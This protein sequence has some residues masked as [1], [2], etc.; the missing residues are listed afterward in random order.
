LFA[1][2]PIAAFLLEEFGEGLCWS[3]L[4][5]PLMPC[6]D[7]YSNALCGLGACLGAL[8]GVNESLKGLVWREKLFRRDIGMSDSSNSS[9]GSL[10]T[11]A[12][13]R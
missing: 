11:L 5:T 4:T 2:D 3:P 9:M 12:K 7:E 6:L 10:Q 1:G 13:G 8:V